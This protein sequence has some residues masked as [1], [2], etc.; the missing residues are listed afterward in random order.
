[1]LL[2]SRDYSQTGLKFVNL[3]LILGFWT[4]VWLLIVH[5]LFW[6]FA[7]FDCTSSA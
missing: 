2:F 7:R 5:G 3:S 1:M 6:T 4:A